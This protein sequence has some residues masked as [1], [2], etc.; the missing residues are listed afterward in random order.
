MVTKKVLNKTTFTQKYDGF[1]KRLTW[2]CKKKKFDIEIIRSNLTWYVLAHRKIDDVYW[3][4]LWYK[5]SWERLEDAM[6]FATKFDYET[7]KK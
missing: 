3:N 6:E 1:L 2:C 4:S 5:T 7:Q